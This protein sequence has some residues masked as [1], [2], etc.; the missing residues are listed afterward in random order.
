[1]SEGRPDPVARMR[2]AN[3]PPP[4]PLPPRSQWPAGM[5]FLVGVAPHEDAVLL[6]FSEPVQWMLMHPR[7]ALDV[8][9]QIVLIA[10][11]I[12]RAHNPG[13]LVLPPHVAEGFRG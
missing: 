8:A 2:F 11:A 5:E 13:G 7:K 9:R 1:M 6:S 12:H 10:E 4:L 3:T